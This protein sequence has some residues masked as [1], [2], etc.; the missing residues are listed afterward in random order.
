M[1]TSDRVKLCAIE[2][3]IALSQNPKVKG[4]YRNEAYNR[5]VM[6]YFGEHKIEVKNAPTNTQQA[7]RSIELT[8][9]T[10]SLWTFYDDYLSGN[11]DRGVYKLSYRS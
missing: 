9:S 5:E 11:A 8:G 6:V 3:D 10:V 1:T 4:M 2:L 7:I